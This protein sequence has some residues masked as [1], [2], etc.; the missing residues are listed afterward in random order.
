MKMKPGKQF[1]E[2]MVDIRAGYQYS[3]SI[4]A[5]RTA[6]LYFPVPQK[7]KCGHMTCSRQWHMNRS[8]CV[9]SRQKYIRGR[10]QLALFLSHATGTNLHRARSVRVPG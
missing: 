6:A 2:C 7:S 8:N 4:P 9:T 5:G 10:T 1:L 3:T